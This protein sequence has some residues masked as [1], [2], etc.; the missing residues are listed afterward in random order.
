M[1]QV[2]GSQLFLFLGFWFS[3]AAIGDCDLI[4][5]QEGIS[6]REDGAT[7][8][9][10]GMASYQ[11]DTGKCYYWTDVI[12]TNVLF[13]GSS[14]LYGTDQ[15]EFYVMEVLGDNWFIAYG[16]C[17]AAFALSLLAFLYSVSYCCST[18]VRPARALWGFIIIVIAAVQ[19]V[20]ISWIYNSPWCGDLG[21]C[22]MGRSTI[23]GIV[24]SACF[25]V[26]G[27]CF[28]AM[29]DYP[30][31][32][33]IREQ[34]AAKLATAQEQDDLTDSEAGMVTATEAMDAVDD[35]DDAEMEDEFIEEEV[36]D[37][38]VEGAPMNVEKGKDDDNDN[39]SG[40][41]DILEEMEEVVEEV[42]EEKTTV[43]S[44]ANSTPAIV[45][46]MNGECCG[47]HPG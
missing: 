25:L 33:Y 9:S 15:I 14:T 43:A 5:I 46:M 35:K 20:G 22:T 36:E 3:A 4:K 10:F 41:E 13:G 28:L 27:I 30:G 38:G 31:K 17:A 23:W 42:V 12:Q 8:T 47:S 40:D 21:G 34:K 19:G 45:Q 16:L 11:D 32:A 7:A 6:V 2:V 1:F 24:A 26:S 18:Q 37:E 29:S 44:E 39:D